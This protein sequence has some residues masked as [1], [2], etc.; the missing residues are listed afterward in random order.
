M[1]NSAN[2]TP[3]H[4]PV[5]RHPDQKIQFTNEDSPNSLSGLGYD[6]STN[7]ITFDPNQIYGSNPNSGSI[8]SDE[9]NPNQSPTGDRPGSNPGIQI[10]TGTGSHTGSAGSRDDSADEL[11]RQEFIN[12]QLD[13]QAHHGQFI[14]TLDNIK[15][16]LKDTDTITVTIPPAN[17]DN[18]T[19]SP[20][21]PYTIVNSASM[22]SVENSFYAT[23]SLSSVI[24][25][26][27][28]QPNCNYMADDT[29]LSY[30]HNDMAR[31]PKIFN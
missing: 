1:L 26:L 8:K 22:N 12:S 28:L 23:S 5:I 10:P 15:P 14:L 17:T 2:P 7:I 21:L 4:S 27:M 25:Q 30:F 16:E 29:S 24:P 20:N 11:R 18:Q 3:S 6:S 31:A 9:E 19:S 13:S